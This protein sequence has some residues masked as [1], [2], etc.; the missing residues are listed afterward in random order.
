[1]IEVLC[2]EVI[3][4]AHRKVE[5]RI[6]AGIY[7]GKVKLGPYFT[8]ESIEASCEEGVTRLAF[9]GEM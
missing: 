6:I 5:S 1:M 8:K 9:L 7:C 3:M 4:E 2:L